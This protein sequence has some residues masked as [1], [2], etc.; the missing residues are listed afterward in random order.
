[1]C[2][3]VSNNSKI[4]G[5]QQEM[6]PPTLASQLRWHPDTCNLRDIKLSADDSARHVQNQEQ[7]RT[8]TTEFMVFLS[9]TFWTEKINLQFFN[10][11]MNRNIL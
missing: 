8:P 2:Q 1:M 4:Y 11:T 7:E 5:R 10:D 9:N 6:I 3:R